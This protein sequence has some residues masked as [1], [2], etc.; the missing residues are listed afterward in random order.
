MDEEELSFDDAWDIVV[1]THGYTNHV[2]GIRSD[3]NQIIC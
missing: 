2:N 1:K 3:L